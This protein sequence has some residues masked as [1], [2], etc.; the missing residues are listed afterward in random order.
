MHHISATCPQHNFY[1]SDQVSKV[2]IAEKKP[3]TRCN[4]VGLIL[5][6]V[7]PHL[8]EVME[9]ADI[10]HQSKYDTHT[11]STF[12]VTGTSSAQLHT[13]SQGTQQ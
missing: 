5:K 7:R 11:F 2:R 3:S 1:L 6:L 13:A 10:E 9:A 12:N 8:I 4:A